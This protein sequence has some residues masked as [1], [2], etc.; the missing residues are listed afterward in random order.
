MTP[1]VSVVM[2]AG[3]LDQLLFTQLEAVRAQQVPEA[4]E[5]VI[6]YNGA[7]DRDAAELR[8][9][10]AALGDERIRVVHAAERRNAA[11]AR[12]VGARAATGTVLAFCDSDDVCRAGWIAALLVALERHGA[13]GGRLVDFGL[14]ERRLRSRPPA[15]PEGL[16]SYLGSP[17]IVSANLALRRDDF[18]AVGGFDEQLV[19]GEDIA[20]SWRLAHR[21]TTLGFAPDAVVDYRHRAGLRRLLRQHYLFGVGMSQLIVRYGVPTGDG[22]TAARGAALLRAN[23]QPGGSRS[24]RSSMRRAALAVGRLVGLWHERRRWWRSSSTPILARR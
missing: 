10:V 15:T 5:I 16:P 19:R 14:D 21:G 7:D 12:N 24:V 3:T 18:W 1:A 23:G 17:Y 4:F 20:I 22:W 9:S 8:R 6:A 11:Y 13:V 2:P